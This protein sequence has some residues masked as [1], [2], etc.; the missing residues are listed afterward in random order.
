MERAYKPIVLS[1]GMGKYGY[2]T[3]TISVAPGRHAVVVVAK[4][5]ITQQEASDLALLTIT[6]HPAPRR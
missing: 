4:I 2:W 1:S 5:G 6:Q 3:V